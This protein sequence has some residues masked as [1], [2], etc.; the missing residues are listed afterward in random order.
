MTELAEDQA[1]TASKESVRSHWEAETCGVRPA[2]TMA[3]DRAAFFAEIERV[4]YQLDRMIPQFAKFS[5]ARGK[6]VLE[7]GIGAGTDFMGWVRAGAEAHGID[8]TDAAIRLVNERL[9][10]EGAR[11]RIARGD[12]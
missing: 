5:D 1:P 11:A 9:A 2:A 3:G 10:L 7:V 12:A 4:R 6:R 8:L